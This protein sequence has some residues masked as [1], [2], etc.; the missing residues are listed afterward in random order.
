M[1]RT[2]IHRPSQIVPSDYEFVANDY[3]GPGGFEFDGLACD[4]MIFSEHVR[5]TGGR[6]SEHEHAGTCHICGAHALYIAK[7]YHAK[8]NSYIATGT[9]C[10]VKMHMGDERRFRAFRER[11]KMGIEAAA[12]KA[13]A[14]KILQ[15]IGLESCW[16]VYVEAN[17]DHHR[18]EEN[19]ICDIVSKL[20]RYG[21]ISSSQVNLL[22][23]LIGQIEERDVRFAARKAQDAKSNYVGEIGFRGDFE[24]TVMFA[25]SYPTQWGIVTVT[26]FKDDAGNVFIHKGT[27]ELDVRK[28]DAVLLKATIK[29]HKDR[30]GIKQTILMRPKLL[31]KAIEQVA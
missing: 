31:G 8:T 19:T 23:K 5:Q 21:A 30:D 24:L 22:E 25:T 26:G 29:D 1:S 12:G 14:Q 15:D 9:D 7:F 11:V 28:G 10:A 16:S 27:A 3:I 20:V 17:R 4:R 13:K 6:Y 18:Y 2:D